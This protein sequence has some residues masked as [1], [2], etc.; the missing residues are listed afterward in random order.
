MTSPSDVYYDRYVVEINADPCPVYSPTSTV[1]GWE[2][3]PVVTP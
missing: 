1:R 2:V 3:L